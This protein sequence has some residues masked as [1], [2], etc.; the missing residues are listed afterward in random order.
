MQFQYSSD[1]G[2]T[3]INAGAVETSGPFSFTFSTALADGPYEARA[4]ATDNAGNSTTSISR[5]L[6][7]RHRGPDRH[8]DGPGQQ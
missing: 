1:G 3:W 6:H 5:F 7:D 8:D 4:I 2:T